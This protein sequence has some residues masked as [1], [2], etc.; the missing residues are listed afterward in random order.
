MANLEYV[1]SSTVY[2][3][4][5]VIYMSNFE[6]WANINIETIGNIRAFSQRRNSLCITPEYQHTAGHQYSC[7]YGYTYTDMNHLIRSTNKKQQTENDFLKTR[8]SFDQ[9][10]V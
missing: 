9:S 3:L 10:Y 2:G 8:C 6:L 7:T 1:I 4:V 5:L